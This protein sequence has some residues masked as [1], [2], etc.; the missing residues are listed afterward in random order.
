MIIIYHGRRQLLPL[1][2]CYLH[3]G[4]EQDVG[5]ILRR[6][7]LQQNIQPFTI[8]GT[9][10][11]GN[12]VCCLAY[13]SYGGIYCRAVQ[14]IAQIFSVDIKLINVDHLCS[15]RSGKGL[16]SVLRKYLAEWFPSIFGP[17]YLQ[18]VSEVLWGAC[19]GR[20]QGDAI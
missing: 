10:S 5:L 19:L 8:I 14:G 17:A 12:I 6:A 20:R 2:A 16:M 18:E 1:V 13:G 9:D 3:L 15:C 7:K 4:R 11:N